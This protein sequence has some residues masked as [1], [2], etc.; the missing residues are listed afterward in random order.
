MGSNP[1]GVAM[2]RQLHPDSVAAI[3]LRCATTLGF[4]S[5]P[6]GY[7][8]AV[9]RV[10]VRVLP[11]YFAYEVLRNWANMHEAVRHSCL[12]GCAKFQVTASPQER[13]R[14]TDDLHNYLHGPTLWYVIYSATRE[15]FSWSVHETALRWPQ[16]VVGRLGFTWTSNTNRKPNDC[17]GL[18]HCGR[19]KPTALDLLLSATR[20]AHE[21]LT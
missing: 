17:A 3:L 18:V 11:E 2:A 1:L 9:L 19:F 10:Q 20:C 21:L 16:T 7:N 4:A 15:D 13:V 5:L 6:D 14:L 12:L 8:F